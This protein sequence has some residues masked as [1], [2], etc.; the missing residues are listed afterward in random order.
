L[1]VNS[2]HYAMGGDRGKYWTTRRT[3]G[4]MDARVQGRAHLPEIPSR[5]R[6]E[7]LS[8]VPGSSRTNR[9]TPYVAMP[10]TRCPGTF[11]SSAVFVTD[12]GEAERTPGEYRRGKGKPGWIIMGRNTWGVG[13]RFFT[14]LRSIET[15]LLGHN[16][17]TSKT[18]SP[19]QLMAVRAMLSAVVSCTSNL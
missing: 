1:L 16:G 11:T 18:A 10:S 9:P 4:D 15:R 14:A 17:L 8:L 19:R 12:G 2:S 6:T 5:R 13:S 7:S 3:Q